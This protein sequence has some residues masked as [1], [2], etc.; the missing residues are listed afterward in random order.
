MRILAGLF[1]NF[2]GKVVAIDEETQRVSVVVPMLKRE[3]TVELA[4][5]EV[6]RED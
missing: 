3:T 1:V 2:N 4:Y 5:D 6:V